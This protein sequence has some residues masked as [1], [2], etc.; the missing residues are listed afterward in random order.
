MGVL[1]FLWKRPV[2]AGALGGLFLLA[3]FFGLMLLTN[4]LSMALVEFKRL[5]P[6][7][8]ALVTGFSIQVYLYAF[9]KKSILEKAAL[10]KATTG[11][12]ASGGMSTG[13]MVACC[14]HHFTDVLPFLGFAAAAAF[15]SQYQEVFLLI[16]VLS[17]AIGIIM[18]LG[19]FKRMKIG[20]NCPIVKNFSVKQFDQAFKMSVIAAIAIVL[21]YAAV[22]VFK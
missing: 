16:G 5:L 14:A 15:L 19:V 17:N 3:I 8:A 22:F 11:L 2:L 6:W 10:N 4:P 1:D 7:I 13:A 9:L 20:K 21:A 12:A 18:M